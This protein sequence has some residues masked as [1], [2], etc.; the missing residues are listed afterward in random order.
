MSNLIPWP[1]LPPAFPTVHTRHTPSPQPSNSLFFCH[2]TLPLTST[3]LAEETLKSH[4][5]IMDFFSY[6]IE[7]FCLNNFMSSIFERWL[8]ILGTMQSPETEPV[9]AHKGYIGKECE[10]SC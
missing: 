7:S 5:L 9:V 2:S 3:G 1:S 6:P 10:I 4:L 8:E